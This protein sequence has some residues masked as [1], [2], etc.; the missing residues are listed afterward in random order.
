MTLLLLLLVPPWA[1]AQFGQALDPV[2]AE[3]FLEHDTVP[4]GEV[5]NVAIRL[6]PDPGWHTYWL[7]AGDAG[8]ATQAVFT[9]IEGLDV[10]GPRW[11][12][13][14]ALKE[15]VLVT[16]GYSD[17]HALLYEM[18][19]PQSFTG[20]VSIA[21]EVNW[22][23]CKDICI[24]GSA[25]LTETIAA[26][27]RGPQ[28]NADVFTATRAALPQ[29][30]S[31]DPG[32]FMLAAG[33]FRFALPPA[34]ARPDAVFPD[35]QYLVN[36]AAP[37]RMD[38]AG[39]HLA[40]PV[41]FADVQS[42]ES[43][44]LLVVRGDRAVWLTMQRGDVP[45]VDAP[46]EWSPRAAGIEPEPVATMS[47]AVA[48]GLAF[49]GGILLNLMPCVFP[50][51][52][53]KAMGLSRGENLAQKRAEASIYT[54]G[55][56]VSFLVLAAG[57]L[58][59]RA[60]GAAL[61]WGF[62]LQN[63]AVVAFLAVLLAFFGLALAGWT[64][65]GMGLMGLG[66]DLTQGHSPRA[67][68]FTGVLAVV[69][70]SPC[71]APF[72]GAALGF[73]ITQP[74]VVALGIFAS[75][76]L[77]LAAPVLVIAWVPALARRLPRPGPWM[78]T[79]KLVMAVPLLLTA[80]WLFTVVAN[81]AG[82]P[83]LALALIALG[84]VALVSRQSARGWWISSQPLRGAGWAVALVLMIAPA[85]LPPATQRVA[86]N[87]QTW[88]AERVQQLQAE[89]RPIFVDFTADWCISCLVN[90]KTALADDVV[91]ELFVQKQ[92]VLLKADWTRQD[93]A[94][95]AG[96]A[97]FDRNG[98]PLYLL[99]HPDGEVEVLPQLLTPGIV[100]KALARL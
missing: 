82:L 79:F 74:A 77:G 89:G 1:A 33:E 6:T 72:M 35:T 69:V 60:T 8:R 70:A 22:L 63:P 38:E 61:G 84:L 50:V 68:F 41:A 59:L 15:D 21:A 25:T 40:W 67:A 71:T 94:I 3:L 19:L 29:G 42:P 37:V 46:A 56:L 92:V 18:T 88:S 5:V 93:P 4:A 58:V 76:G 17:Q 10:A 87:W 34:L 66:Q 85:L 30:T 91:Q 57:L 100:R 13:P 32:A 51:L 99:Y 7:N 73:A 16:Y 95:T 81:Q 23:V 80:A 11:P 12:V 53:L 27:P 31:A 55:V 54:L 26:G 47:L 98:V 83:A 64:Q 44:R 45:A 14:E 20:S 28:R 43:L 86:G 65:M 96:L 49:L 52:A 48:I 90:E 78:N 2:R 97:A 36:H 24:P 62:Q 9:G 39:Q 75:L